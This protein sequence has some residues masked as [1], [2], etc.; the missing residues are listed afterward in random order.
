MDSQYGCASFVA[1]TADIPCDKLMRISS[2]RC[3]YGEPKAYDGRGRPKKHGHKF[4]LND[5]Q[6]WLNEDEIVELEDE[7]LGQIKIQAWLKV[8]GQLLP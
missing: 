4:K 8:L 1:Q 6:T 3:F 2:N 7:S 5:P